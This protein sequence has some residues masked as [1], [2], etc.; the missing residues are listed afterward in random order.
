MASIH[1]S[2]TISPTKAELLAAEFGGPVTVLATYRFDDPSGEVGVE[3]FIVTRDGQ[4]SHLV[5]TYRG[6]PLADPAAR[7]V[8]PMEHSVLGPRWVYD[9]ST[10]P[11]AL[12]CLRRAILGDQEQAALE[13]VEGDR[14][15]G[16]REHTV[17]FEAAAEV[18]DRDGRVLVARDLAVP[19]VGAGL[20]AHWA[21]GTAPVAVLASQR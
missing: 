3:G 20:V 21:G 2:A 14:V 8:S 15:T 16:V 5:L 1:T 11:V 18:E 9:G 4:T 17:T 19:L 12:A 13:L 6:A 7:L 10:D